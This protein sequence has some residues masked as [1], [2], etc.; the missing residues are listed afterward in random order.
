MMKFASVDGWLDKMGTK[1][2]VTTTG[3]EKEEGWEEL[4]WFWWSLMGHNR[5]GQVG[6]RCL[7]ALTVLDSR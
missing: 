5:T 3:Q 4:T 7:V 2:P 6:L 1:N